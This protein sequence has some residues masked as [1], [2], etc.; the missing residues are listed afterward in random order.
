[1]DKK[2]L[3]ARKKAYKKAKRK[4]VRPW[5]ILTGLSAPLLAIVMVAGLVYH[6]VI[7]FGVSL[8]VQMVLWKLNRENC[9]FLWI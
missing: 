9:V 7:P 4:A 5:S 1:M 2:E 8:P 6:G 3:K